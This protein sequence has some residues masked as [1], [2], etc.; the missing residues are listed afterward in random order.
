MQVMLVGATGLVGRHVLS[1]LL[2]EDTVERVVAPTR[3]SLETV[4]AKLLNPVVDFDALPV[5]QD[6]WKADSVICTLGTTMKQAGSR[7]AFAR[8]DHDYPLAV[9]R[10]A[11]QGGALSYALNSAAGADPD[12]RFF[13][14]RVKGNLERDLE[15][16]GYVSLTLVRPGLI[17][18][19]RAGRRT[20]EHLAGIALRALGPVLPRRMRVNPAERIATALVDAAL[21]ARP[22]RHVVAAEAL[23]D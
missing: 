23:A 4:H 11:L 9:A 17:G 2:V 19:E 7:E 15:A 16:L 6:W 13:Y 18:G 5:D 1:Q 12:S 3:R 22:G 14:N 10:L 20:G 21:Q 8:V